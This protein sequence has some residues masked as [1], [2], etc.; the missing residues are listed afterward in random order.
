MKVNKNELN[1][2]VWFSF[3]DDDAKICL[4]ICSG[5]DLKAIN[6]KCIKKRI[7]YKDGKRNE[8]FDTNEKLFNEMLWDFCIVDWENIF[9]IDDKL[10]ECAKENKSLFMGKFPKFAMFVSNCLDRITK[11][12]LRIREEE[13][14]N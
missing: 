1:P 11:D 2:G 9:D 5:D 4:R 3:P 8:Y 10:I 12:I 13:E 7:E 6:E 14:K